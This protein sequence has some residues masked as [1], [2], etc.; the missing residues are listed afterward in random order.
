MFV[1]VFTR[2]TFFADKERSFL[3]F[4]SEVRFH[5]Y[6]RCPQLCCGNLFSFSLAKSL[7]HIAYSVKV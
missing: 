4:Y 6:E 2:L 3:I 5:H 1:V 7:I